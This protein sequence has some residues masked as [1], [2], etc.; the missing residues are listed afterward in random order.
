LQQETTTLVERDESKTM[1][2]TTFLPEGAS[3]MPKNNSTVDHDLVIRNLIC[4]TIYLNLHSVEHQE[5]KKLLDVRTGGND[6]TVRCA[7]IA[8]NPL[9]SMHREGSSTP[10]NNNST[11]EYSGT[12][13]NNNSSSTAI[14]PMRIPPFPYRVVHRLLK[15]LK[16]YVGMG[17]ERLKVTFC[18]L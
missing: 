1:R 12:K 4:K 8:S 17:P 7:V 15:H 9:V 10:G 3:V 13:N 6:E 18:P 16:E 2:W 11:H 5:K 14:V